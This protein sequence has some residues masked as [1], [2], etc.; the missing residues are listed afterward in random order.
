MSEEFDAVDV[1]RTKRDGGSLSADQIDWVVDAYTRGTVADEQMSA[2]AMAIYLR[3]MEPEETA[4]WTRAMIASGERLD[5]SPILGPRGKIAT[6]DKHSTGGGGGK[7]KTRPQKA[8]NPPF[9]N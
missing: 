6:A 4:R 7:K 9:L 8:K 3:G 5:F 1:I 2:L